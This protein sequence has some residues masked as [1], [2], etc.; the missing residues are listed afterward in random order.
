MNVSG[1][2][3]VLR[4]GSKSVSVV[5][6]GL[7]VCVFARRPRTPTRFGLSSIAQ[8]ESPRI[9]IGGRGHFDSDVWLRWLMSISS[10]VQ[11]LQLSR[12]QAVRA[13]VRQHRAV[14]RGR[15]D[16]A[17]RV[18]IAVLLLLCGELVLAEHRLQIGRFEIE[19][20]MRLS[21]AIVIVWLNRL[22]DYISD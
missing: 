12:P 22:R 9:H 14:G 20:S 16:E 11:L 4:S 7:Q 18:P 10:R 13:A 8:L 3:D 1:R 19:F 17:V 21:V 15:L 5:T 2:C 6:N